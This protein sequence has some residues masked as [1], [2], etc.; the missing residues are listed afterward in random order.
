M[1]IIFIP[2]K[3]IIVFIQTEEIN[4]NYIMPALLLTAFYEEWSNQ[5]IDMHRP[6]TFRGLGSIIIVNI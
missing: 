5:S 2:E 6:L 1:G 4:K 3:K